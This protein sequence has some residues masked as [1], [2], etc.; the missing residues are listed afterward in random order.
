M[1]IRN[2]ITIKNQIRCFL[3]NTELYFI[4]KEI[5][6]FYFCALINIE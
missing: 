1:F 4:I 2:M 3:M 6:N 5:H